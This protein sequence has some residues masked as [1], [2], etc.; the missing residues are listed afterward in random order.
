MR[1]SRVLSL[2]LLAALGGLVWCYT[3]QKDLS[4]ANQKPPILGQSSLRKSIAGLRPFNPFLAIVDFFIHSTSSKLSRPST[5]RKFL[6][7]DQRE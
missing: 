1:P 6:S 2:A 7:H 3:L 5:I 4:A